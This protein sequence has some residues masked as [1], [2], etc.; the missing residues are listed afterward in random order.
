MP[1]KAAAVQAAEV[2]AAAVHQKAL[3]AVES[4]NYQQALEDL[5]TAVSLEPAN[6]RWLVD[7]GTLQ[8]ALALWEEAAESFHSAAETETLNSRN[9]RLWAS[10]LRRCGRLGE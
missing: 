9:I 10:A 1:E 6:A 7:R 3:V 8:Y 5:N 2:C 4:G